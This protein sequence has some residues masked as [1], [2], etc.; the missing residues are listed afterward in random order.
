MKR[1]MST[2]EA[3]DIGVVRL[4]ERLRGIAARRSS[5]VTNGR[6]FFQKELNALTYWYE[7]NTHSTHMVYVESEG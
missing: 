1:Q 3:E 2:P 7:D 5:V 6:F 4:K